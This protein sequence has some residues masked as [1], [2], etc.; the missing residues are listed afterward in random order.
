MRN[1]WLYINWQH[2]YFSAYRCIDIKLYIVIDIKYRMIL[3]IGTSSTSASDCSPWRRPMGIVLHQ[4]VT[5]AAPDW[6]ALSAVLADCSMPSLTVA[7]YTGLEC[8]PWG[9]SYARSAWWDSIIFNLNRTGAL[10]S[11]S[12]GELPILGRKLNFIF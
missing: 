4:Q 3:D 12:R 6:S 9:S 11:R 5:L 8:R 2:R 10:Y 7:F 1:Q